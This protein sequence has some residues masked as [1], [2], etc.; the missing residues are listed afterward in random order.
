M[1]QFEN[2]KGYVLVANDDPFIRTEYDLLS[3]KHTS[4]NMAEKARAS[5]T[6]AKPETAASYKT[7]PKTAASGTGLV[8]DG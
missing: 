8:S 3:L 2:G 5:G 7:K 1:D 4:A 6:R